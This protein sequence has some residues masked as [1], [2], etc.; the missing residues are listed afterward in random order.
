MP[1]EPSP[2]AQIRS[3]QSAVR[4]PILLLKHVHARLVPFEL[5]RSLLD[6]PFLFF[7]LVVILAAATATAATATAKTNSGLAIIGG[8]PIVGHHLHDAKLRNEP[9]PPPERRIRCR[10]YEILNFPGYAH[11]LVLVVDAPAFALGLRRD[12][13]TTI[14]TPTH[15]M[16][17]MIGQPTNDAEDLVAVRTGPHF[18]RSVLPPPTLPLVSLRIRGPWGQSPA[19]AYVVGDVIRKTVETLEGFVAVL[20]YVLDF[21]G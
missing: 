7:I 21:W 15:P 14:I 8:N 4:G 12:A 18:D 16:F 11:P 1:S 20:A 13:N 2:L 9:R 5:I 3:D 17:K 10:P 19:L 6:E